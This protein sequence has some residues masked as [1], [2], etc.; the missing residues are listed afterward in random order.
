M[1]NLCVIGSSKIIDDHLKVAKDLKFKFYSI[2]S[3]KKNSKNSH[4]LC[5]KY[6]FQKHFENWNDNIKNSYNIKNIVYLVA[7]RI[8]DTIKILDSIKPNSYVLVEKPLSLK[9]SDFAKLKKKKLNILIGY[10]RIFYK[11]VK[12]L[13]EKNIK[14]AVVNVNLIEK[15]K[16]RIKENSCHIISILLHVFNDFKIKYKIKTNK[17]IFCSFISKKNNII[18]LS[19]RENLPNNF[20]IEILNQGSYILQ[21]PLEKIY[22][23]NKLKIIKKKNQR[24]FVPKK[25][26]L[27]EENYL[28]YKPGFYQQMKLYKKIILSK[29]KFDLNNLD[30]GEKVMKICDQIIK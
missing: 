30:F 20:S 15:N 4:L 25:N 12:F 27:H 26:F 17:Y 2:S 11:S 24:I 14:N 19:Y 6:K 23:V 7:P 16:I 28:K 21:K 18:N 5:K 1:I 10:N 13:K 8:K 3:T 29:K 22:E 9:L